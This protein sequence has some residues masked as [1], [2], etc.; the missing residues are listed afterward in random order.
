MYTGTVTYR[1]L[2]HGS[3][4]QKLFFS[5]F[6]LF[7]NYLDNNSDCPERKQGKEIFNIYLGLYDFYF[8]FCGQVINGTV[9]IYKKNH[10]FYSS[11]GPSK[12]HNSP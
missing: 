7:S 8:A 9:T 5:F 2:G 11:H 6:L 3:F 10:T 1:R 4:I 12:H